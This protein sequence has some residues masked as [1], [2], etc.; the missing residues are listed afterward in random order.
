M[1]A[2]RKTLATKERK[3][4]EGNIA[5]E[6]LLLGSLSHPFLTTLQFAF[7]TAGKA[8]LVTDFC[9]GGQLIFHLQKNKAFSQ[10]VAQFY[11][12]EVVRTECVCFVREGGGGG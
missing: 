7:Q 10:A 6:R 3:V 9:Q 4:H 8:C 11:S 12:A 5:R 1:K 2:L